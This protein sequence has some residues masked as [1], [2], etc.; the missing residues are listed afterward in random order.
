MDIKPKLEPRDVE[1]NENIAVNPVTQGKKR[2]GDDDNFQQNRLT[3]T[4]RRK[5]NKINRQQQNQQQGNVQQQRHLPQKV[6]ELN[7]NV[8]AVNPVKKGKK[9]GKNNFQNLIEGITKKQKRK[10]RRARA[11]ERQ[12][13]NEQAQSTGN[14]SFG[15]RSNIP[16]RRKEQ[17]ANDKDWKKWKDQK[18]KKKQQQAQKPKKQVKFNV[19]NDETNG[20]N[21]N[22]TSAKPKTKRQKRLQAEQD[23]TDERLKTLRN[24]IKELLKFRQLFKNDETILVKNVEYQQ[25]CTLIASIIPA[26]LHPRK[27][28]RRYDDG[29]LNEIVKQAA[30]LEPKLFTKASVF[31]FNKIE[32]NQNERKNLQLQL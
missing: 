18:E 30:L 10:L 5:L 6:E 2:K 20:N 28:N 4:Q 1:L 22:G 25:L 19:A 8:G 12:K 27:F 7:E 32:E 31:N 13:E 11:K 14:G 3:K 29:I 17:I 15:N 26:L 16:I 24:S 23:L 21:N 9:K